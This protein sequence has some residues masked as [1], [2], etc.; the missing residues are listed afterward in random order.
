MEAVEPRWPVPI[1]KP[2]VGLLSRAPFIPGAAGPP[3]RPS[4][5]TKGAE[6][7]VS[8]LHPPPAPAI[9]LLAIYVLDAGAGTKRGRERERE[10]VEGGDGRFNFAFLVGSGTNRL[11]FFV[12][13]FVWKKK[14]KGEEKICASLGFQGSSG[15]VGLIVRLAWFVACLR[16]F[17]SV[18][19]CFLDDLAL[20]LARDEP[21]PWS[22]WFEL[23]P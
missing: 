17:I 4:F 11:C 19:S 21:S 16:P 22:R 6:S 2:I 1:G 7:L 8:K 9:F 5:L 15:W 13:R 23:I 12:S 10:R 14:E 20:E 3:R 18:G